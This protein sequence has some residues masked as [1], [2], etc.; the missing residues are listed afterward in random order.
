[1]VTVHQDLRVVDIEV[2]ETAIAVAVTVVTAHQETR[3]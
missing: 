3:E 2:I 1:M